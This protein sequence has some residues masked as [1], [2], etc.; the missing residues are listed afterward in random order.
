MSPL[1][2]ESRREAADR[3]AIQETLRQEAISNTQTQRAL[4]AQVLL[5]RGHVEH[6][7]LWTEPNGRPRHESRIEVTQ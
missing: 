4:T 2:T 1:Q 7:T 3:L 5:D 6:V